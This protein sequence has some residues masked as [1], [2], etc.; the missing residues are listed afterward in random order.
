MK[1]RNILDENKKTSANFIGAALAK[2]REDTMA[3]IPSQPQPGIWIPSP[4]QLGP[5][6]DITTHVKKRV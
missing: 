6:P 2:D 5:W 1:D 3:Q 4:P